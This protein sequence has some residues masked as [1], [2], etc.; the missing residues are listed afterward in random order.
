[1]LLIFD[2]L[3]SA[4]SDD[5]FIAILSLL[6]LAN[7]DDDVCGCF[8]SLDVHVD[9]AGGLVCKNSFALFV[10]VAAGVADVI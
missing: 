3:V 4:T 1:M 9:D 10:V 6:V 7:D 5:E 8:F 2:D